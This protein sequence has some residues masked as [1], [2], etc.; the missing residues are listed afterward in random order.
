MKSAKQLLVVLGA[1][2]AL[3]SV[4][5]AEARGG[6]AAAVGPVTAPTVIHGVTVTPP[7]H[8]GGGGAAAAPV[9]V[10]GLII[11]QAHGQTVVTKAPAGVVGL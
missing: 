2:C 7:A 6:A 11:T 9:P 5:N 1:A 8:G 10:H 4:A 3:G